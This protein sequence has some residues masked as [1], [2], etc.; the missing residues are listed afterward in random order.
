MK[1]IVGLCGGIGAGKS[2]VAGLLAEQGALVIAS[3]ELNHQILRRPEVARQL[4][5]WW[6]PDVLQ[7]DGAVDRARVAQR[8]FDEPAERERLER[9]VYPLIAELR[10]DMIKRGF[11]NPAVTIIVLDSPLLFESN[12]DRRC[13][14][15]VF[16]ETG[17]DRRRDRLI[18]SRGWNVE[19]LERRARWQLPVAEKRARSD[20]ILRNDGSLADLRRNVTNL[21]QNLVRRDSSVE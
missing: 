10:E 1:P 17:E 3:D 18:E 4:A 21:Y 15:V 2:T 9:L 11:E 13:D 12:L 19:E 5:E 14:R 20:F 6:G 16:V 7:P 8:V